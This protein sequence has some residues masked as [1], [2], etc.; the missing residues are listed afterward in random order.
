MASQQ[1]HRLSCI[2]DHSKYILFRVGIYHIHRQQINM[3]PKVLLNRLIIRSQRSHNPI[4]CP[5]RQNCNLQAFPLPRQ[6]KDMKHPFHN[7]WWIVPPWIFSS[8]GTELQYHII[9]PSDCFVLSC[10]FIVTPSMGNSGIYMYSI[11]GLHCIRVSDN[12]A[13]VC[14]YYFYSFGSYTICTHSMQI[15]TL[16]K[17]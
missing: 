9:A 6:D 15:F 4:P 10:T 7:H 8:R 11:R 2:L 12:E 17:I 3:S 13:R 14:Y 1:Y 16:Q 5:I